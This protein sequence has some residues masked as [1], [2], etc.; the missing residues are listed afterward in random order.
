MLKAA[1][2][3][4]LFLSLFSTITDMNIQYD[5]IT[6]EGDA[7]KYNTQDAA[8]KLAPCLC[9]ESKEAS[10]NKRQQS[11]GTK[12]SSYLSSTILRSVSY[13]T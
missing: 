13:C 1:L 6:R 4:V 3:Y 11:T 10:I 8:S 7:I 2:F 9:V 5:K 12:A